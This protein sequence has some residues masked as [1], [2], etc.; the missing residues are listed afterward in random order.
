[1]YLPGCRSSK[2]TTIIAAVLGSRILSI[3]SAKRIPQT[4]RVKRNNE[5]R[6]L[7]GSIRTGGQSSALQRLSPRNDGGA[8]VLPARGIDDR[9]DLLDHGRQTT[10]QT[11][12]RIT[13]Y[14]FYS[15]TRCFTLAPSLRT[16]SRS[17]RRNR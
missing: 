12:A 10:K 15:I 7:R 11:T 3:L 16:V 14:S 4:V 13:R 1:M 9:I 8:R 6:K 17:L 5:R 2:V